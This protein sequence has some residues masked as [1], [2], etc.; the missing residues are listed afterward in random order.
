MQR[1][2]KIVEINSN[3]FLLN[4]SVE[5]PAN[6]RIARDIIAKMPAIKPA[7][8]IVA[9]KLIAYLGS[10]GVIIVKPI[11]ISVFIISIKIYEEFHNFSTSES[12]IKI[13]SFLNEY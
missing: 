11:K 3:F 1:E 10:T 6:G 13:S 7:R 9:P 5:N 12:F 2:K 4:L 8:D